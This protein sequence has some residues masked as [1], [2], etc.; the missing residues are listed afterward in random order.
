MNKRNES[1]CK[2]ILKYLAEHD[3][4]TNDIAIDRFRCYRLSARIHDLRK[5]HDIQTE[6]VYCIDDDGYPMKYAKY[7][8]VA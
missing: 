6:M 3:Y 8:L 1:H 4:I 7:R 5:K 2:Q